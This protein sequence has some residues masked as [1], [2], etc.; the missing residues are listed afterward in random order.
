MFV[1]ITACFKLLLKIAL[2]HH[3]HLLQLVTSF[4]LHY[5]NGCMFVKCK[6]QAQGSLA[7]QPKKLVDLNS[8][9]FGSVLKTVSS[10][11]F[12]CTNAPKSLFCNNLLSPSRNGGDT[13]RKYFAT[14][15]FVVHFEHQRNGVCYMDVYMNVRSICS[16][17]LTI[18][19]LVFSTSCPV[20]DQ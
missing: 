16:W 6:G 8:S 4:S 18:L 3:Q 12:K 14:H 11:A 9:Q 1:D 15:S 13:K 2:H 19:H 17:M 5:D 20:S 10:F 7:M